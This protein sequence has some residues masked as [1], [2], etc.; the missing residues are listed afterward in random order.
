MKM[1]CIEGI[2]AV[3]KETVS[4]ALEKTLD[5]KG[6][7][8]KRVSFPIY[9][10]DFG[11]CIK[12]LLMG[13][14]GEAPELD[15]ELMSPLYTLDRISYFKANINR[16]LENYDYLICDRSFYSNFM[17]QASKI[18]MKEPMMYNRDDISQTLYL[19]IR[20]NFEWEFMNTNLFKCSDVQTFVLTLSEEDSLKQLNNRTEKDTNEKNRKYLNDCKKFINYMTRD[21]IKEYSNEVMKNLSLR[22]KH[23]MLY[24][25]NHV[26]QIEVTH[27]DKPEDIGKATL[28]TVDK[29]L[30]Y[31]SINEDTS[32]KEV[33]NSDTFKVDDYMDMCCHISYFLKNLYNHVVKVIGKSKYIEYTDLIINMKNTGRT[34]VFGV[35]LDS[36]YSN[37]YYPYLESR[38]NLNKFMRDHRNELMLHIPK[39]FPYALKFIYDGKNFTFEALVGDE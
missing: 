2:D 9:E 19:W 16:L 8:V 25:I 33:K 36:V 1:I 7:K 32:D 28:K 26:H 34:V 24:Y 17:Y 18:Y 31:L 12:D 21:A 20:K 10:G 27:A 37:F 22:D 38:G 35:K 5:D 6:F 13:A 4:K 23:Y 29:I 30:K 15:H 11:K 14:C 39:D 3:G